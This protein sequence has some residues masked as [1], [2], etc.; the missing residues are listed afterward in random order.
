[1]LLM[2]LFVGYC[3]DGV[4]GFVLIVIVVFV[5]IVII[6]VKDFF[7]VCCQVFFYEVRFFIGGKLRGKVIVFF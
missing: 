3:C 1:M 7:Y 5:S 6:L 2:L 4:I